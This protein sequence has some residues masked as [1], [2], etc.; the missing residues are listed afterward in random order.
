MDE[1]Q[2]PAAGPEKDKPAKPPFLPPPDLTRHTAPPPPSPLDSRPPP[3]PPPAG[4][5]E[6]AVQFRVRK[7][8]E[9]VEAP[10]T[11]GSGTATFNNRIIATVIDCAVAIGLNIGLVFILP[12]FA[13]RLGWLA[14]LAY[15]LTRDA[16][17][18]LGGQ[19]VGKKAV[20]IRA[21][22]ADGQP[23]TGNWEKSLVRNLPLLIPFLPLVELY[24]LLTREGKTNQG[25]RLGD[26]WAK[27]RV[28][29]EPAAPVPTD[30]T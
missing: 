9:P 11:A 21:V 24:V 6:A 17:P 26:E 19:S 14:A 29:V 13:E 28:I 8:G 25:L 27:T 3:P 22:T 12:G 5:P 1:P 4:N 7:E 16:L 23:L 10:V 20:G 2:D 15:L 18:F 30:P